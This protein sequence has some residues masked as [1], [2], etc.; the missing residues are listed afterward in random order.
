MFCSSGLDLLSFEPELCNVSRHRSA[1]S[2]N[3]IV[4]VIVPL[5]LCLTITFL[6]VKI[7]MYDQATGKKKRQELFAAPP[8]TIRPL[9]GVEEC[10]PAS[11]VVNRGGCNIMKMKFSFLS[12][13]LSFFLNGNFFK[14][15]VS[16][17]TLLLTNKTIK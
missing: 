15:H 3:S 10:S 4:T 14:L 6:F 17:S 1:F 2:S 12:F 11:S 13:F 8:R 5:S 9:V 7:F 16:F